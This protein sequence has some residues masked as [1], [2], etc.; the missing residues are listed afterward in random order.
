MIGDYFGGYAA[1]ARGSF[2]TDRLIVIVNDLDS[3]NPLPPAGSVLSI[4]ESGPVGV[5]SSSIV[6]L[7]QLQQLLRGG[8]PLP[9]AALVG[10]IADNGTMT[11]ALTISQIQALL[12]ATPQAYD[13]VPLAAPPGT[14]DAGVYAVFLTRNG[15]G[16]TAAYDAS[17]SGAMLQGGV[18]TLTGGADF[19]AFYFYTHSLA[20]NVPSPSAGTGLM[21]RPKVSDGNSPLPRDRVYFRYGMFDGVPIAPGGVDLDRFTPGFEKT[22]W[23]GTCSVEMRVPF[24]ATIDSSQ[25]AGAGLGGHNVEFGNLAIFLKTLLH[26]SD[27][28]AL[29][30]GLGLTTPTGDDLAVLLADGTPLVRVNNDAVHLKPYVA[31]LYTPNERW[32]AHGFLEVDTPANGNRLHVNDGTGLVQAGMLNDATYLFADAGIGYWLYQSPYRALTGIAPTIELHYN[33]SLQSADNVS[34]GALTI[35]NFG[36]HVDALNLTLGGTMEF[37]PSASLS[38][39][40]VTPLGGGPDQQLN[41]GFHVLLDYYPGGKF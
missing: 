14:Y 13:I 26:A 6:N 28:W 38:L 22:F 10:T 35:G 27:S 24:A 1:G 15:P 18:D 36:D 33:T 31:G 3:P 5:Y 2:V 23:G 40:Y 17:A 20:L 37:G 39:G 8:Q 30:A 16:G 21:G 41:S 29:S 25:M 7:Q 4:T 11:T 34:V 12:A 19:D 9:P 32:F